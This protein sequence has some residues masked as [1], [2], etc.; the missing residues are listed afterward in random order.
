LSP[1]GTVP[2]MFKQRIIY[3]FITILVIFAL[4]IV[5]PYSFGIVKQMQKMIEKEGQ[6]EPAR[7]E[8]YARMQRD[9]TARLV[10][11]MLPFVF[12]IFILAFIISIFFSEKDA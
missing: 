3:R 9:L 10:E 2:L 7:S 12:Y 4:M 5:G 11:Q 6:L 8:E 1:L